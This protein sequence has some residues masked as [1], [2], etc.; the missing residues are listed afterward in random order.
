MFYVRA[1]IGFHAVCRYTRFQIR[2]LPHK[3]YSHI[4]IIT[5]ISTYVYE[6]TA[7]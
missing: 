4:I 2:S 3:Q 7:I 6:Y 1:Q 5:I